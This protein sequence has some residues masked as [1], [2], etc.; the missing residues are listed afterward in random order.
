MNIEIR[1]KAIAQNIRNWAMAFSINIKGRRAGRLR[2]TYEKENIKIIFVLY[3]FYGFSI[4]D[5]Y[6]QIMLKL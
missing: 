1:R 6:V 5:K 3:Y 4:F 2:P